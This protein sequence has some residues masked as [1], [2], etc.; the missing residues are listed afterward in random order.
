MREA[1]TISRPLLLCFL[2]RGIPR[3]VR[4]SPAPDWQEIARRVYLGR[5][6]FRGR[7]W[8]GRDRRHDRALRD[9][10]QSA[11]VFV[12]Q[13]LSQTFGG[14][15]YAGGRCG[16]SDRTRGHP[17]GSRCGRS[18]AKRNYDLRRKLRSSPRQN[19]SVTFVGPPEGAGA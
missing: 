1:G 17:C 7:L 10:H 6:R 4:S 12:T 11:T 5:N 3:R 15:G 2:R 13:R 19:R 18:N 8:R 9:H 14:P 16:N